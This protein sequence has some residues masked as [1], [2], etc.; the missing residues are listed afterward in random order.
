[1]PPNQIEAGRGRRAR[2]FADRHDHA[3]PFRVFAGDR[4]LDEREL[5]IDIATRRAGRLRHRA[6]D[7]DLDQFA[8]SLAVARHLFLQ[9][10]RAL[11]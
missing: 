5:A 2:R 7:H 4:R 9:D 3:A 8:R 10:W 6:L 1:M 11:R